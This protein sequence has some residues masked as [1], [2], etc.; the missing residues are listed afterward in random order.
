MPA[1]DGLAAL[2]LGAV[3]VVFGDIGTSPIYALKASFIGRHHLPVDV[4]H[5]YGVISLIFWTMMIVVTLK[6]VA[7][8]LRADNH[9]EGGSFAL[10]A[11][12]MRRTGQKRWTR[13]LIILGVLAAALFYGDS[14][15]TPAISVLSAVEGLTSVKANLAPLV[16]PAAVAI[17]VGLFAIQKR[18]TQLV[19]NL[20]GPVMLV[21]FF[22][23]A[24]LGVANILQ[25]PEVLM[26]LSPQW[27]A[28]FVAHNPR[29]AFL[30]LGSV[31][32]AVTGAEALYADMGHFGRRPI[33]MAWLWLVF[34]CLLLNY[35]GQC[36]LLLS[37]PGAVDSPFFKL[38]P[39]MLRL[40]LVVLATLATIIASQAVISG[41]F[42]VT[43]Q[44][45][46]LGFMPRMK[47]AH[48]S[49]SEAGQIY[50]PAVNWALLILV[51]MLVL[52][53]GA[54]AR[55]AGAYGIAVTGTMLITTLML[56][57]LALR[58]WRI[59]L[60]Y[61]LPMLALFFSVDFAYF[62]SNLTKIESGG[63][64]PL[65]LGL[66]VFTMLTTWSRGRTLLRQSLAEDGL[67]LE[68]FARSAKSS[69]QRVPG[70]AV[71]LVAH[72]TGVPSALLHNIKHNKIIHERVVILTVLT[73]EVPHVAPAERFAVVEVGQGFWRLVI[74][75]GFL[76]NSDVPAALKMVTG[77]GGPFDMMKTSFFLS[78]QTLVA[79][80][81][82]GMA[83]WREK[84]FAWM[85]RNATSAMEFFQLPVNRVVELGTQVEM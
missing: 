62:I 76:D 52:G 60:A 29:G 20:F 57:V 6:Y 59:R 43:H 13:G 2:T 19:G 79:A 63:W 72:K 9:G 7:V 73:E 49:A 37:H 45:I 48:T 39:E 23:L 42:S 21:Y 70:T 24:A 80:A 34:P 71:F 67:P 41:A 84:L 81:K 68:I 4:L 74:R 31:V 47:T 32:L 40:P 1:R 8:M 83:L 12:I 78:R 5:L 28:Q 16:M 10:L 64:V 30:A 75:F 77:C 38:A 26:A 15:L 55:L 33:G 53:F 25:R 22:V 58:V 11:L 85:M 65:A 54:S 3:G 27:I 36:A 18:G 82:P 44:A 35:L 50:L 61:A 51:L 69:A 46:Q 56:A 14:V 66:A 17:L